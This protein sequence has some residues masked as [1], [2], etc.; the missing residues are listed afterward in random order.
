MPVFDGSMDDEDGDEGSRL[1]LLIVIALL[2]LFAFAGVVYYAYTEGVQR[3]RADAPRVIV[4][5]GNS[6]TR[7]KVFQQPAPPDDGATEADSVPPPPSP[8]TQAPVTLDSPEVKQAMPPPQ[9]SPK[10][11]AAPPSELPT[12]VPPAP[13]PQK[14]IVAAPA[15]ETPREA[16]HAPAQLVAPP[17]TEPATPPPQKAATAEEPAK[18]VAGGNYLLQIGSYK[19]QDEAE[20]AWRAFQAKHPVVGG[21][22]SDVKQ[23]DLGDK[24]TWFR[25]RIGSFA[26]KDA[27]TALC[28]KLKADG[29]S[30]FMA[31]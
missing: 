26:D 24:G 18:A 10:I 3:G 14:K 2:V 22:Q 25:L 19:S 9:T 29:A 7:L 4:A 23:V 15:P 13:V 11:A 6:G 1:P 16:T 17:A 21:Y 5:Q 20:S 30:C 28:S 12:A 8:V 27:A 31:K